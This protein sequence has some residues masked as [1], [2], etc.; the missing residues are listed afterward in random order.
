MSWSLFRD[1]RVTDRSNLLDEP[2]DDDNDHDDQW[3]TKCHESFSQR[4]IYLPQCSFEQS[5][6]EVV[7]AIEGF[8]LAALRC[9]DC[10]VFA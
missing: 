3:L 4:G 5:G 7:L 6:S 10:Y 1:A 2:G 9:V 8:S